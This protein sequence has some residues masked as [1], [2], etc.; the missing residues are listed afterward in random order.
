MFPDAFYELSRSGRMEWDVTADTLILQGPVGELQNVGVLLSPARR[1]LELGRLMCAYPVEFEVSATGQVQVLRELPL[2]TLSVSQL[3]LDATLSTPPG[4]VVTFDFGDGTGLLDSSALPHTYARPG[5]YEVLIRLAANGRLTEYRAAVVVSRQVAVL[6]PCI[7]VPSVQATVA[8]AKI[9]LQPSLQA[10]GGEA[11]GVRWQMDRVPADAGSNPVTFTVEPGRYVL[12]FTA[13]RPLQVRF[14]SQQRHVPSVSITMDELHI[15]SNRTFDPTTGVETTT[16]PNAF[17]QHVF[18][19]ATLS[20]IDRWS[21]E[22]PLQ[23]NPSLRSVTPA[24]TL[25]YDLTEVG[26]AFLALEYRRPED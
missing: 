17:A 22:L 11:L 2:L 25:Q 6:P 3:V 20:P 9:V 14:Y 13:I 10:A 24:D 21:L 1:R 26:D 4:T 15:A 18:G 5:R 8:G 7:A 12:R 23:D 19:G 16:A